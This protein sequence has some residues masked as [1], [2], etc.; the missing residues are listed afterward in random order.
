MRALWIFSALLCFGC[1][2]AAGD[3]RTSVPFVWTH[4]VEALH[5][6]DLSQRT[7]ALAVWDTMHLL[8]ALQG[9][10]N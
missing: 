4:D 7:N 5:R 6:L 10:A 8:G 1:L 3:E 2:G 9:L